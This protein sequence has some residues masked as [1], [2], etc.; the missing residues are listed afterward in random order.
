LKQLVVT[1]DDF[2]AAREVNDAV[3]AAHRGGILTAASLMVAATASADAIARARRL[4]ALRIGL[5]LVL[6]EGRPVL[7]ASAL[8]HLT[9][10]AGRFTAN[11]AALGM[12]LTLSRAARRE[13]AAEITAQFS[14]FCDSGLTLDHCNA[15]QHFHL[16][17]LV[18]ELIVEIGARFGLRALRVPL[19]PVAVL[20]KVARPTVSPVT[21]LTLPFAMLLRGRLAAAGLVA[22]DS[23]FG[24]RWSGQM[25]R[26]RLAGLIR[27]LPDGLSEIYLHPATSTFPGSARGYRYRE[28][29]EALMAPEVIAA[30]R[31]SAVRL[32]GFADFVSC[33]T[34]AARSAAAHGEEAPH[35]A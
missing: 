29:L 7:P 25:T 32:G 12:V 15:H 9:N 20:R 31:D 21:A 11:P 33:G 1:A 19:E 34:A 16:H 24:L 4:H 18:G 10:A 30:V 17:P 6:L 2:G 23:V 8:P 14:A 3:E 26:E 27:N 35:G 13:L 22:A 28:E 5:H